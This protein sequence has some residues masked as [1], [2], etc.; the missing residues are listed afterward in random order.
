MDVL[1]VIP[2]YNEAD[3]IRALLAR[4]L[5]LE[6]DL[7]VLVVDDA[8]PDGTGGIVD[9]L[10]RDEPRV[11]VLHREAKLG[12]GAAYAAGMSWG[13]E[14]GARYLVTMDGDFSHD[15]DYVPALVAGMEEHDVMI[16]SRYVAGGGCESWG[17]GRRFLSHTANAVARSVL[18]LPIRDCTA[19]MRCY[20][21]RVLE[22]IDP[23]S[24]RSHGYS[25]L[26]EMIYRVH[27]AG[28]RIG[29]HPIIFV[30]RRAGESKISKTEIVKGV[31]TL[32]RL[33]LGR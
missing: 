7:Q 19:G 5:A 14:R 24:V 13:L 20:S 27:R 11:H 22:C 23:A 2:T 15:P 9:E 4:L 1:V 25:Y 16:G 32:A 33:R 8:S 31:W 29:E 10:M 17:I 3:N 26:Q 28:F 21:R 18:A 6:L 30:D 12:V